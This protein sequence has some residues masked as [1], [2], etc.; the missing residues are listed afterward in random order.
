MSEFQNPLDGA[1][2][3]LGEQLPE[4]LQQAG[5]SL[6]LGQDSNAEPS[7]ESSEQQSYGEQPEQSEFS[8]ES[9][10]P[11]E[12]AYGDEAQQAEY[13]GEQEQQYG[14][15][16]TEASSEQPYGEASPEQSSESSFEQEQAGSTQY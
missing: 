11:S 13:V 2:D 4:G 5:E 3:Q 6:G 8:T 10:Q 9:A 7:Q 12:Q 1:T 14:E 16:P 15:Q